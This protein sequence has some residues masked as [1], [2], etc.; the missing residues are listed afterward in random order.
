MLCQE[1]GPYMY[2]RIVQVYRPGEDPRPIGCIG[3]NE[4]FH[5]P[6]YI[7]LLVEGNAATQTGDVQCPKCYL[8]YKIGG[9]QLKDLR[10]LTP[11]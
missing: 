1:H 6:V 5:P 7:F 11:F 2:D 8:N 3:Q 4:N 9:S 10:I